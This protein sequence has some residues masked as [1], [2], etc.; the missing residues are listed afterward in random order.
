MLLIKACL[1]RV[2]A[3]MSSG[4][5]LQLLANGSQDVYISSRTRS[6]TG[7]FS[8]SSTKQCFATRD[9]LFRTQW[10]KFIDDV[11][12]ETKRKS[13]QKL[14]KKLTRCE[15]RCASGTTCRTT[16]N[17]LHHKCKAYFMEVKKL[18]VYLRTASR[19][20]NIITGKLPRELSDMVFAEIGKVALQSLKTRRG[21]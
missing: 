14:M 21:D 7:S 19:S 13:A 12:I 2:S 15:R 4:A 5:L 6:R 9:G 10:Q 17:A 3:Q 18:E 16:Q 8:Q 11:S 1:F 20:P